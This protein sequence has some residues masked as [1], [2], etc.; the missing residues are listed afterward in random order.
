MTSSA[1][2]QEPALVAVRAQALE[3]L[4]RPRG[5]VRCSGRPAFRSQL[6][7][8]LGCLLDVDDE[9][10]AW[11]CLP[12]MLLEG[13]NSHVPDFLVLRGSEHVLMDA[14]R[15]PGDAP[16][17]WIEEAAAERGYGYET[18]RVE[19]IRSG[20]RLSNARDL[21]RYAGWE[22]PLGDRV[23]LLAGLDETGSMTITECLSAFRETR[24]IAGLSSLILNRFVEIDLDEAR[25]G[26]ETQVRR[27]RR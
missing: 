15:H 3:C 27:S 11:S 23:R 14:V 1:E 12:V 2:I 4:F 13:N 18:W 21:L 24:P 26:P 20:Y 9:V 16:H 25:V 7:R 22:C 17:G 10:D 5:T 6:A 8:D 19:R